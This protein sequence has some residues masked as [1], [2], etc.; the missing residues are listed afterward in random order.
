MSYDKELQSPH[1][2]SR[3]DLAGQVRRYVAAFNLNVVT[4]TEII[5]T[6][7]MPD[8]R[9]CVEFRTPTGAYT[10]H[11]QES[12]SGHGNRVAEAIQSAYGQ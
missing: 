1:Q 10:R 7:Q 5:Q 11:G 8:K 12:R 2:L 4:S 6:T 9:W 3:N